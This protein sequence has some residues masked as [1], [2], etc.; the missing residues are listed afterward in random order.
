[1]LSDDRLMVLQDLWN[2]GYYRKAR[3]WTNGDKKF[4]TMEEAHAYIKGSC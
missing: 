4:H 2:A 1:M 3:Y